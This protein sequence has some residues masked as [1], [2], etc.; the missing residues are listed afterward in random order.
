M[1]FASVTSFP[2]LLFFW[3]A[4]AR[5]VPRGRIAC[6]YPPVAH[7]GRCVL[8]RIHLKGTRSVIQTCSDGLYVIPSKVLGVVTI[9]SDLD[10]NNFF[11]FFNDD[12][13]PN[14]RLFIWPRSWKGNFWNH[15]LT[16]KSLISDLREII[17]ISLVLSAPEIII[18]KFEIQW[19][20]K[21]PGSTDA[22]PP[23]TRCQVRDE[24]VRTWV[25]QQ[26]SQMESWYHRV[27]PG[28]ERVLSTR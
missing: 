28:Q 9:R 2:D 22:S 5:P 23:G 14:R 21:S 4:T 12:I 10:A 19:L 25:S 18:F 24:A 27:K 6:V 8:F 13:S 20:T 16:E 11:I 15:Y 17:G 1:T 7:L 26:E 3:V